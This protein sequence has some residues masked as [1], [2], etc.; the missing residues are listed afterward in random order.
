MKHAGGF[1]KRDDVR[2][3]AHEVKV[4]LGCNGDPKWKANVTVCNT[5]QSNLYVRNGSDERER[6]EMLQSSYVE[7]QKPRIQQNKRCHCG[8]QILTKKKK[9]KKTI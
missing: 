9:K 8:S 7:A 4:G 2:L 1:L 6:P 3:V 5:C